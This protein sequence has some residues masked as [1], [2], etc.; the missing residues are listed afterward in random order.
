MSDSIKVL[1]SF[2]MYNLSFCLSVCLSL[3]FS[4]VLFSYYLSFSHSD[5]LSLW[6]EFLMITWLRIYI[7]LQSADIWWVWRNWDFCH[8]GQ[9]SFYLPLSFLTLYISF[10]FH[11]ILH[12]SCKSL[13]SKPFW[14][15]L[16]LEF[17]IQQQRFNTRKN[18][19]WFNY[20]PYD[21]FELNQG[22][23]PYVQEIL[24]V[25]VLES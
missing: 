13:S 12:W 8:S 17:A 21:F 14:F 24:G 23:I 25:E 22:I 4:K 3:S 19:H 10:L 2:S 5:F 6:V 18:N 15:Q 9:F 16:Q 20:S 7:S 1:F 11:S